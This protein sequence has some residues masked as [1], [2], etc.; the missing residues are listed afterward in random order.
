MKQQQRNQDIDVAQIGKDSYSEKKKK[1]RGLEYVKIYDD[2]KKGETLGSIPSWK[3]EFE[4]D[5]ES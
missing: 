5:E 4:R 1:K 3:S 2:Y